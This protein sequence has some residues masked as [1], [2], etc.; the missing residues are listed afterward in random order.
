LL[1]SS[2]CYFSMILMIFLNMMLIFRFR[3]FRFIM[4]SA[5]SKS[6]ENCL[7]INEQKQNKYV[8]WFWARKKLQSA[9]NLCFWGQKLL[10]TLLFLIYRA[11]LINEF[12]KKSLS[13]R[14]SQLK[15][16]NFILYIFF[17]ALKICNQ[18]KFGD[19]CSMEY[20]HM[21]TSSTRC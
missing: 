11:M 7:K 5:L 12:R 1:S 15:S 13:I 9:I 19:K 20:I 14:L 3:W 8:H 21:H 16:W 2:I 17:R 6:F 10:P 4:W 18:N